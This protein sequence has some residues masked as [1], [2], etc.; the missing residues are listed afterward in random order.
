M[1]ERDLYPPIAPYDSGSLQ[2]DEHHK[3]Y[4]EVS[5]NP[6][7]QPAVFL[8]GG[9]G[10]GA[11]PDHRRFFDP[12]RY[13][14][15]LFDQ[16]GAGRSQPLGETRANTTQHLL[17]DIEQLRRLLAVER[18][19]VFGG[20]WGSTLALAYAQVH[21]ERVT[22]LVLRGIFLGRAME[23][24]WWLNG[25]KL[26]FPE[27]WQ[28]FAG[29]LPEAERGNLLGGYHRRLVDPDPSVHMPAA[30]AWARYEAAC[31]TLMPSPQT[32]Q[33]FARDR[34]ALALARLEAHYFTNRIFLQEAQLLQQADRIAQIPGVIV[35]GRYDMICPAISAYELARVWPAASL[36][37]VPDAGHSAMEPGTRRRLVAACDSFAEGWRA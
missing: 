6:E 17:A 15:L 32:L 33:A 11:A 16:R 20:S 30:Q 7:G 35:Q 31:S 12:A 3:V 37:I 14:V 18:W 5:G 1:P 24:D 9:P 27:A 13:R 21:P 28:A 8:H 29:Y 2:V 10:G 34:V 23:L 19:L 26:V 22:A 25:L 36:Q 4:W